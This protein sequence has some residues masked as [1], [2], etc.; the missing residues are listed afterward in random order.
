MTLLTGG[1]YNLLVR[2]TFGGLEG[3]PV[4]VTWTHVV[5]SESQYGE[6]DPVTGDVVCLACPEGGA[7]SAPYAREED[8]VAEDGWWTP[9]N[10]V[11]DS[12]G[13][14]LKFYE[15]P[16]EGACLHPGLSGNVSRALCGVGYEG[17]LCGMCSDDYYVQFKRCVKC[18]TDSGVSVLAVIAILLALLVC[19]GLLFKFREVLP[20]DE[21]KVALS[22]CQVI[23]SGS[24]VY[25]IPWPS[26]F[27][28]LLDSMQ[29]F[30]IDV[31]SLTRADCTQPISFY[32]RVVVVLVAFKLMLIVLLAGPW[33]W[34]KWKQR[35]GRGGQVAGVRSSGSSS[36][37]QG[38]P[39]RKSS[40]L[41]AAAAGL[42]L[43]RTP[44]GGPRVRRQSSLL[45]FI[46]QYDWS[47]PLR[48]TF[49]FLF[50]VYGPVSLLLMRMFDCVDVAGTS[51]LA[52][53]YRLACYDAEWSGYAVYA[54]VM[55]VLFVAGLPLT[56]LGILVRNRGMLFVDAGVK[57]R[58][59]FLY[60]T[61]GDTAWWWEVEELLRKLLLS[62]VVVL[63]PSGSALQV[64]FAVL[65]S[66]WAHVGHAVWKPWVK[67]CV[68]Y[69]LQHYSLFT[70]SFVFLMGLLF[71]VEGVGHEDN[72]ARGLSAAMVVLVVGFMIA[73][74]L[75][76]CVGLG[77]NVR[78][79]RGQ[80]KVVGGGG[81]RSGGLGGVGVGAWSAAKSVVSSMSNRRSRTLSMAGDKTA[82]GGGGG[83]GD[84][85]G[86]RPSMFISNPLRGGSTGRS[87]AEP[88]PVRREGKL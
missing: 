31:V 77:R 49:M 45:V 69:Y 39:R 32:G 79:K 48:L 15:C 36:S 14:E 68:T 86:D 71:K 18:E 5:C 20:V 25:D 38:G 2:A 63:M 9:V 59:G 80:A 24:S 73:S 78:R 4:S 84:G 23:A 6:A 58:W 87:T 3:D 64:T 65:I 8:I 56:I 28:R 19:G 74:V 67:G 54:I 27:A 10:A 72:T 51:W 46:K 52:A 85:T 26:S 21:L 12:S 61:Y 43:S 34:H 40:R 16:L 22:L 53:D 17:T 37:G 44:G 75:A 50:V 66:G 70:T 83:G 55:M 81:G 88:R 29:L 1:Q 62:A 76:L 30:L 60:E 7:C 47:R 82:G 33:A 57:E 42:P 13:S 11:D 35:G 41:T